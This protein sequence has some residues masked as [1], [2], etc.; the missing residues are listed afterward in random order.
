MRIIDREIRGYGDIELG[1]GKGQDMRAV[2]LHGR[3]EFLDL[4]NN[5]TCGGMSEYLFLVTL[6]NIHG[7]LVFA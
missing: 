6:S 5:F 2:Y 3:A 1:Y 7:S 4:G